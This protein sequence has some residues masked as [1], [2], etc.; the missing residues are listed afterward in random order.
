ML[1]GR[2]RTSRDGRVS[3]GLKRHCR[4]GT[5]AVSLEPLTF[6]E[7]LPALSPPPRAHPLTHHGVLAPTSAWRTLILPTRVPHPPH[8]P[9]PRSLPTPPPARARRAQHGPS[10]RDAFLPSM[11]SPAR[12]AP[13]PAACSVEHAPR[14]RHRPA[15]LAHHRR[16]PRQQVG[17]QA[18]RK[19][20]LQ[21]SVERLGRARRHGRR[22]KGRA[23]QAKSSCAAR[24]A[25]LQ[26]VNSTALVR[27]VAGALDG[28]R[29]QYCANTRAP[30]TRLGSTPL[31]MRALKS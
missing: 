6:I 31:W 14:P 12:T 18:R 17:L 4:D 29:L 22:R 3:P 26:T 30:W 1:R 2:A 21:W 16:S 10:S 19:R 24:V 7:R 8:L 9:A 25:Q 27:L 20:Q 11:S 23:A 15:R 28:S 13:A 5:S